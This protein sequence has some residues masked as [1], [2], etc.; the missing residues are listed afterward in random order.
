MLVKCYFVT[1]RSSHAYYSKNWKGIDENI[2]LLKCWSLWLSDDWFEKT[3]LYPNIGAWSNFALKYK[4]S[5]IFGKTK[6]L[7][8]VF[9]HRKMFGVTNFGQ[10]SRVYIVNAMIFIKHKFEKLVP[11]KFVWIGKDSYYENGENIDKIMLFPPE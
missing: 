7:E 9:F 10:V 11:D 5:W 6:F 1:C 3:V 8:H 4:C 2:V